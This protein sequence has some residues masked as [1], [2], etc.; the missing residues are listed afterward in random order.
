MPVDV[1]ELVDAGMGGGAITMLKST[2]VIANL[3]ENK[4]MCIQVGGTHH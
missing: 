4:I 2:C 3:Q 1:E